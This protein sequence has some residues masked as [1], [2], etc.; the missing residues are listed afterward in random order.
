[1]HLDA[2]IDS[3]V[4][5][6]A[7]AFDHSGRELTPVLCIKIVPSIQVRSNFSFWLLWP[8]LLSLSHFE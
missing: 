1:M 5:C 2:L 7:R 4:I 8:L 3:D 6:N